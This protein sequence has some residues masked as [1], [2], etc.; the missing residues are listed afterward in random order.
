MLCMHTIIYF[1]VL[2]NI[3]N[4]RVS[5]FES[6]F[7]NQLFV[8]VWGFGKILTIWGFGKILFLW[9]VCFWPNPVV[10]ELTERGFFDH[11]KK[12]HELRKTVWNQWWFR[13]T[14]QGWLMLWNST[15]AVIV[16]N[17]TKCF[18]HFSP[19]S[20]NP[21]REMRNYWLTYSLVANDIPLLFPGFRQ[22]ILEGSHVPITLPLVVCQVSLQ[23]GQFQSNDH[24]RQD[25]GQ[26]VV[27]EVYSLPRKKQI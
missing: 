27:A 7:F 24:Y 12:I 22:E 4:N 9:N 26:S 1:R 21:F 6:S 2:V 25:G 17:E 18:V 23:L 10:S 11:V 15:L 20:R 16:S 19:F 13:A 14:A 8:E 3:L 5:S